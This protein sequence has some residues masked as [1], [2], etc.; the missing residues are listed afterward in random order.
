MRNSRTTHS[1]LETRLLV[2]DRNGGVYGVTY[3][4]RA[5]LSDADL[6]P[7]EGLHEDISSTTLAAR[8]SRTGTTPAARIASSCHNSH[9]S[10]TLGPKTRQMNRDLPYPDGLTENQLRRWNRLGL[11]DNRAERDRHRILPD[12]GALG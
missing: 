7:P 11:F 8:A 3:K 2:V 12:T 9:T 4:W 1:V 5:D 10:G 6:V